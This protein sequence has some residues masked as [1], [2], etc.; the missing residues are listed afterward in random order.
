ME[1][2]ALSAPLTDLEEDTLNLEKQI[3]KEVQEEYDDLV[4]TLFMAHLLMK[5]SDRCRTSG[6]PEGSGCRRAH[7]G[8]TRKGHAG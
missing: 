1:I 6:S 5:V 2:T 7:G 3:T 4:K 8:C